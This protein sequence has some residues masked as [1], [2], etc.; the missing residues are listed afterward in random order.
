VLSAEGI[1]ESYDAAI[2]VA[3]RRAFH[4]Y[5]PLSPRSSSNVGSDHF[6]FAST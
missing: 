3:E 1:A 4:G 2:S 5:A 6:S